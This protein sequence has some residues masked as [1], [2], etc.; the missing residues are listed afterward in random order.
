VRSAAAACARAERKLGQILK[1]IPQ[2][3]KR[4]QS[5]EQCIPA[6]YNTSLIDQLMSCS[7]AMSE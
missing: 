3:G 7:K 1:S 2:S 4:Q 5:R 6:S